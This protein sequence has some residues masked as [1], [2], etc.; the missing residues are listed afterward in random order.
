[1][2]NFLRT[3]KGTALFNALVFLTVLVIIG[4]S[5]ATLTLGGFKFIARSHKSTQALN[6]AEAGIDKALYEIN[7]PSSTYTSETNTPF[8]NGTFSVQ[9]TNGSEPNTKVITS[10]GYI[11]NNTSPELER[12]IRVVAKA[13]SSSINIAFSYAVQIGD[14]GLTMNSNSQING[15]AYSNGNIIGYSNSTI[16]GDAYAVTTISEPRPTAQSKHPN[17]PSSQMPSIDYN[18]W[19]NEATS[20][21]IHQGDYNINNPQQNLGPLK[22]VGNFNMNS[23]SSIT[24][25]GPIYVTGNFAM[26]SNSRLY[27]DQ[28]FGTSGTVIIVDGT[29][30]LNSNSYI[31]S[32]DATPKGYILL[33]TT[34]TSANA[35]ELNSNSS[36]G[37][38]YALNGGMQVNSNGKAVA[39]VARK[40]TLNSNA[41]FNYDTGLADTRF[42][43]GPG[44]KWII[45]PGS[46]QKL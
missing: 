8:G 28:A 9:I 7:K 38:C 32:T 31:Y 30:Q 5:I 13:E 45:K 33:V 36:N 35:L 39:A 3:S 20:G 10:T 6:I 2:I 43:T 11:P 21:G 1:M 17:S 18:F 16:T 40:L 19:K 15:N 24:L 44:G 12:T 14:Q 23:N 26:N 25:K 4:L 42:S 27:L 34:S 46:W 37:I 29:I 22:I 41:T